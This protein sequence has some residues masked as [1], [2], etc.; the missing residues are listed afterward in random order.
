MK[1]FTG[2]A[3]GSI[4]GWMVGDAIGV[5]TE[6]ESSKNAIKTI[7]YH[8]NFVNGLPGGGVFD[9]NPGQFSDDTE[10][11]LAIL[12]VLMTKGSYNQNAVAKM[13]NTWYKS[14]PKD[15]GTATKTCVVC[16]TAKQ[17]MNAAQKFNSGSLSNGFLMRIPPLVAFYTQITDFTLKDMLIALKQDSELTH[18]HR[19][20]PFISFYYGK[21]LRLAIK[22]GSIKEVYEI[23]RP[24]EST[25]SKLLTSI[26]YSVDKGL[27]HFNYD[28]QK[29]TVDDIAGS[30]AGFVGF[31]MWL[32]LKSIQ[33]MKSYSEAMLYI[34]SLGGDTDT[35]CCIIGAVMGAIHTNT[36]PTKWF[37]SV[38][39][40]SD[41]DRF[42]A[43]PIAQP[44]HWKKYL[45]YE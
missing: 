42:I 11:G 32:L 18:S 31:V 44:G 45:N 34:M 40:Y 36:I 30:K 37:G 10:M 26:Y 15:I 28:G 41:P 4:I 39:N 17:M 27:D 7:H 43:Y 12:S 38:L 6:F 29:Y 33:S 16:T 13:Y 9:F 25:D 5:T 24:I 3:C 35:N 22:G 2:R 14:N 8:K 21:M 23:G 19:E 20:V 1:Q